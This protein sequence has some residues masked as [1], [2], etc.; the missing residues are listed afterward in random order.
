MLASIQDASAG[1]T[2]PALRDRVLALLA[3]GLRPS[4]ERA[5][6]TGTAQAG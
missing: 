2:D 5:A 4:P 3:D 6:G 1:A